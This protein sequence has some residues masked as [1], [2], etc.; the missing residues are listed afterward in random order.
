MLNE[1]TGLIIQARMG[2]SRLPGKILMPMPFGSSQTLLDK[3]CDALSNTGGKVVVATSGAV[4][5]D[6]I[7]TFCNDYGI[8]CYRGS[9]NDVFSRFL[10]VQKKQRFRHV[11]RFT[12][13]NPFIDTDKLLDFFQQYQDQ[14][15]D[16]AYSKGMPLGMNFE[17]MKGVMLL[18]LAEMDLSQEEREHV[19]L[20]LHRESGFKKDEIAL[21]AFPNFRMTIDTPIDYA[22]AT[23][24][25]QVLDPNSTIARLVELKEEHPWLFNLNAGVLQKCSTMDKAKQIQIIQKLSHE[26]GFYEVSKVLAQI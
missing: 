2:S 13:D 3:I 23:L 17:V 4:E 10:E 6:K 1:N 21:G 25:T 7:E 9:E 22:Q 19:T 8:E 11:F 26:Q 18:K 20:R 15:L 14:D 5:N 16:F 24:I 12:A